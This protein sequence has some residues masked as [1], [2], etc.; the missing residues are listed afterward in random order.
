MSGDE[1]SSI[2][3]EVIEA[4]QGGPPVAVATVVRKGA[5]VALEPGAKLLVR[6][7]GSRSGTLGGGAIEEAVFGD[8]HA[9][10]TRR[11]RPL[12]EARF[13]APDGRGVQ[14]HEAGE[15]ECEVM[16]EVTERP[17]TVVIVGGGHVGLSVATI[18]AHVGFTVVVLDDRE[19]FANQQRFPMADR[20]LCG[21]VVEELRRLAIDAT[22]YIVLVSRGHKQDE[23]ALGEV[24]SSA[25]AYVGMIGSQRR[26]S[27]VLT[28]LAR[29][30][31]PREALDRVHTPIGLD[32]GAET[33]EEIAVSVMA[34]VI[35]VRRG[36]TGA[37][38][39][40]V[41]RARIRE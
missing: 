2:T 36:G 25:A 33:P 30:G 16:I 38:M 9:A 14:R 22:T 7:D 29:E 3:R 13:Y 28:H 10:L 18:A 6:A 35:A 11:P 34:E 37:K 40:E 31:A 8:A 15:D 1:N 23:L 21:D 12:A 24:V 4:T 27:T 26:V 19:A 17:A 39:S 32:I 41:R 20:V 5:A